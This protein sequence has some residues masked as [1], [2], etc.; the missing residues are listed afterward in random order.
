M[1]RN[2]NPKWIWLDP[3]RYPE[4]QTT[5]YHA[6]SKKDGFSF[7]IADFRRQY[8]FDKRAVRLEMDVCGDTAFRLWVNDRY[9]GSGPV[10]VGGDYDGKVRIPPLEDGSNGATM[11]YVYTNRYFFIIL[12]N[13]FF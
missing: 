9:V 10:C 12:F 4:Y 11:P 5:F 7:A 3:A 1:T 13:R 6:S 2:V 8:A